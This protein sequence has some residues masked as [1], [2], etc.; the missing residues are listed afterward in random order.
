MVTFNQYISPYSWRYG[1][2]EMRHI[3]SEI[4]KRKLWRHIWVCL[5]TVQAQYKLATNEQI[6]DLEKHK[7]HI[8]LELAFKIEEE[9]RHDLMAELKVFASQ[10][11]VG[12][13]IIHLGAT[14]MDIEDNADAIRC[15]DSLRLVLIELKSL[16]YSL[17]KLIATY[18]NTITIAF[19]HLQPAEPTT[20]GYRFALY[21][22]DLLAD[23]RK[24]NDLFA[25][26]RGKGFKGAVGNAASYCQL[27]GRREYQKFEDRLSELLDLPFYNVTSQTYPRRQDYELLC[28]L[29]GLGSTIYKMAFDLRILQ[30]PLIGEVS[31]PFGKSQV[32]S[33]AMPFKRNPINSEKINSLG[34]LLAQ[35]PAV[36]WHNSAHSLLERTLDD[37]GNRRSILPEAFLIVDE[38]VTTQDKIF[39]NLVVNLDAVKQNLNKYAPFAATERILME[40]VKRGADRQLCHE[41]LR[42]HSMKAWQAIQDNPNN[43]LLAMVCRD[44]DFRMFL[45]EAEIVML[46][47]INDYIG[48]ASEKANMTSLEILQTL[49]LNNSSL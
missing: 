34:R 13:R 16:L 11:E 45:S 18:A 3:W 42:E 23:Y 36:A 8:D 40:L 6:E 4:N 5:A 22:Q 24:L 47:D 30:S 29:A 27:L 12:G 15:R 38:I 7:V 41:K 28:A 9:I 17:Q 49:E 20:I 31:E 44:D 32:G 35:L 26:I 1:S 2:S 21:A 48:V 43:P 10:C 33:S 46:F 19:T 37:S 25:N 14:S 39:K